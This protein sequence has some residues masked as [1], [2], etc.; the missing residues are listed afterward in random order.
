MLTKNQEDI[1]KTVK[2]LSEKLNFIDLKHSN[3]HK[4]L[5]T[6]TIEL[7]KNADFLSAKYEET[8]NNNDLLKKKVQTLERLNEE[9]F[10]RLSYVE[11]RAEEAINNADSVENQGRKLMLEVDGIPLS[12]EEKENSKWCH[13]LI[14]KICD[15]LGKPALKD[16]IDIAHRLFNNRIIV[17]FKN[18]TSRNTF[19]YS[20]FNLKGKNIKD[21]DFALA[22][23]KKGLI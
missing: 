14:E 5:Q 23:G 13:E 22:E 9:L 4:A 18:R 10:T 16:D 20:K 19:Y 17:L 8:K 1:Q 21:L 6:K 2:E 3:N 12:D 11:D 7:E 15:L